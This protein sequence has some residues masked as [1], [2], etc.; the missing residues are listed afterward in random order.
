MATRI[1]VTRYRY[2]A[3]VALVTV[4]VRLLAAR[5]HVPGLASY[6][7]LAVRAAGPAEVSGV[8]AARAGRIWLRD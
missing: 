6:P 4:L 3:F 8:T 1:A 2:F 5:V 7:V